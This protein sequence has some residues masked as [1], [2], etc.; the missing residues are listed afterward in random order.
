MSKILFLTSDYPENSKGNLYVDLVDEFVRWGHQVDV[1]TPV[2]RR[3]KKNT[4]LTQNNNLRVLKIKSL[5]LRGDV[6]LFEKGISTLYMGYL[7]CYAISKYLK[8]EAYDIVICATLPI[9]YAPI[10]RKLKEKHGTF[11][12]L[13]HKDFFPQSAIDLEMLSKNSVFYHL[14]RNIERKLYKES[15]M[16]GVMSKKNIEFITKDNPDLSINNLEIC[17][18]SIMPTSE[19]II[20]NYRLKKKEIRR[21][22]NIPE[23]TTVFIYG[24]NIS[25]AQ[26]IDFIIN[27]VKRFNECPDSYLLFVGSGNEFGKLNKAITKYNYPNVKII[28]K[29]PKRDYDEL[30][31]SCE[32]G[33]VFLDHRF[34]IA[35]IPSRTLSHLDMGQPILAATDTYTDFKEIIE[36]NGIGLWVNSKDVDLFLEKVN[37]LTYDKLLRESMGKNG[38][39][40]LETNCNVNLSYKIIIKHLNNNK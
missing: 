14:F 26:G 18:N 2:E 7:Y 19:T 33:L 15:D 9:T 1:I 40:Y 23:D 38:R 10:M 34:S 37:E 8:G 11:T 27:I 39:A 36:E 6:N 12:Y 17:P 22:Y 4:T 28:S 24:G 5:N 21:K 35:N 20:G 25:R 30:V 31:L 13:L 16:I 29:L 3:Y 32:V